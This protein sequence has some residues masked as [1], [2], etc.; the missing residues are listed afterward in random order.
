[1]LHACFTANLA[2]QL[3]MI[4]TMNCE[5]LLNDKS[6]IYEQNSKNHLYIIQLKALPMTKTGKQITLDYKTT[7]TR[8]HTM[9]DVALWTKY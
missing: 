8:R 7:L 3:T 2:Y 1:M 4:V 6:Y 5:L 9:L